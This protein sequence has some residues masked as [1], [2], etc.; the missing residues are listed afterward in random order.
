MRGPRRAADTKL[1]QNALDV[2]SLS[3]SLTIIYEITRNIFPHH[4]SV[5][6][7]DASG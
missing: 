3:L 1:P 5:K 2:R 4:I 6:M 7:T